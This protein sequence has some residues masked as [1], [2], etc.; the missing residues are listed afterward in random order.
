MLQAVISTV[1]VSFKIHY[2]L[3]L[4]KFLQSVLGILSLWPFVSFRARSIGV[5]IGLVRKFSNSIVMAAFPMSDFLSILVDRTDWMSATCH[6]DRALRLA[7]LRNPVFGVQLRQHSSV[8]RLIWLLLLH[9]FVV[10]VPAEFASP[11]L[12]Q[13][14][15]L[16]AKWRPLINTHDELS[17][18]EHLHL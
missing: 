4:L 7:R 15:E 12:E 13:M 2:F 1:W 11:I 17:W 9:Y 10:D 16:G 14:F 8:Q 6:I 18:E 3:N 5:G